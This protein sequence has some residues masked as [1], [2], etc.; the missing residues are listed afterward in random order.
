MSIIC[1]LANLIIELVKGVTHSVV[2]ILVGRQPLPTC[3]VPHY[4]WL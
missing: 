3:P 1:D 2:R 4:D